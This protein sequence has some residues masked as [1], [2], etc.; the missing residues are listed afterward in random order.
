MF[1]LLSNTKLH[2]SGAILGGGLEIERDFWDRGREAEK[3]GREAGF[4][5]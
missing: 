2:P 5:G 4:L 3:E 1:Y